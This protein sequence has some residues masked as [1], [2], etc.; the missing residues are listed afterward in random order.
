MQWT[1]HQ[2]GIA[3]NCTTVLI[4]AGK[5]T[6]AH[7]AAMHR[8]V[9][10]AITH[11]GDILVDLHQVTEIDFA[12]LQILCAAH[13]HTLALQKSLQVRGWEKSSFR[14]LLVQEGVHRRSPC[15]TIFGSNHCLLT[16]E[17]PEDLSVEREKPPFSV[18]ACPA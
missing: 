14:Q 17:Q 2:E 16:V 9:F 4:L 18:L 8:A 13:R 10:K 3:P 15:S 11:Q 1:I 6:I 7:A 12:G 5:A